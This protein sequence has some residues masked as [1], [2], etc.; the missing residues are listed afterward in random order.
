M[1]FTLQYGNWVQFKHILLLIKSNMSKWVRPQVLTTFVTALP[2]SY[3][4]WEFL[5][6]EKISE[7]LVLATLLTEMPGGLMEKR[8]IEYQVSRSYFRFFSIFGGAHFWRFEGKFTLNLCSA[9]VFKTKNSEI[10][11]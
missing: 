11:Y 9:L 8:S 4:P 5:E 2:A 6:H 10:S 7:T 1:E 3:G